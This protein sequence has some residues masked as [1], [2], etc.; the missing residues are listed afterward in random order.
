VC[1]KDEFQHYAEVCRQLADAGAEGGNVSAQRAVL[2]K[3]AR[4]WERLAVEEEHI[5]DLVREVDSLFDTDC[6][7]LEV[8]RRT[9]ISH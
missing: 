1:S 2:G 7:P 6:D 9:A 5:A 8:V 3:M 4:E